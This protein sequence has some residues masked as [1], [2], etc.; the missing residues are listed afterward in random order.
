MARVAAGARRAA[1]VISAMITISNFLSLAA[2][3]AL[4]YRPLHRHRPRQGSGRASPP[5][6]ARGD[7]GPRD[8]SGSC[9][10]SSSC[11]V[12]RLGGGN[13]ARAAYL[14][15]RLVRQ[16]VS[17]AHR[18]EYHARR[19][20]QLS[21]PC[22]MRGAERGPWRAWVALCPGSVCGKAVRGKRGGGTEV[23]LGVCVYGES[24]MC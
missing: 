4:T 13:S 22:D 23:A 1:L 20:D 24:F 18:G 12:P 8:Q 2:Y 15:Q 19:E 10:R 16:P 11:A 17:E 9:A 21:W 14:T 3:Q 5:P 6:T 7:R